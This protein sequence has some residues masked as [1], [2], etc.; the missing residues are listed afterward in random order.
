MPAGVA[1]FGRVLAA[2]GI[3]NF[4]SMLSRLAIPWLAAL[5][6]QATP[7]QM[8]AL[9]LADVAAGA[10]G[11]LWLGRWVDRRGKRATMLLADGA[12]CVLLAGLGFAAWRGAAGFGLLV[13]VAAASGLLT[14]AF[15]LARSAW[16][17]QRVQAA[18]LPRRNAQLSIAGSVSEAAAFALGGWLYQ[19]LG[20]ALSLLVDGLSYAAS[21]LCLR[22]VA[23]TPAAASVESASGWR[24]QWHEALA[25][26]RAIAERP[27]LR[28]VVGVEALL[29]FGAAASGTS[30]MLFVSRELGLS[31]G[32]LGLVF[33]LGAVGSAAGA[34]AAPAIG[35]RLGA[36]RAM[37]GGLAVMALGWA[38]VPL[39]GSVGWAAAWLITQQM[40]GDAGHTLLDVHDRSLR[41]TA[42]PPALLAR[43]DAGIR[44]AGQLATIAGALAGGLL[45]TAFGL[46]TVLWAAVACVAAASLLAAWRLGRRDTPV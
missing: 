34:A 45:G 14:M 2:E 5:Q 39:A 32:V 24:G 25:G 7:L 46:R 17:A 20:V 16:M 12:R 43:A 13:A 11:S 29:A 41:Q 36:G 26:W 28:A 6:L 33:A 18:E 37:A 35:R 21:A 8:A 30:Y 22:G 27:A 3:S 23:E 19:G 15:E 38:C 42:V 4:G 44:S 40:V 31:T 9:L 10:V 1:G